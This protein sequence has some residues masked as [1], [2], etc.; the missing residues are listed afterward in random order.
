[1]SMPDYLLDIHGG[2]H[3]AMTYRMLERL[4]QAQHGAV[5]VHVVKDSIFAGTLAASK[6]H[7]SVAY[8][9]GSAVDRIVKALTAG[10]EA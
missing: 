3:S 2:G 1:M 6:L 4:E 7:I 9:D 8:G 10:L 5:R